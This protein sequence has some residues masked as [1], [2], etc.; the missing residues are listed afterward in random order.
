MKVKVSD[1][2]HGWILKSPMH[3]KTTRHV[4]NEQQCNKE[5]PSLGTRWFSCFICSGMTW[6]LYRAA[7][8]GTARFNKQTRW[9][10]LMCQISLL[11]FVPF[12]CFHRRCGRLSVID[13][14]QPTLVS[15]TKTHRNWCISVLSRTEVE[16]TM[17]PCDKGHNHK[18]L[19]NPQRQTV[20][21]SFRSCCR[22]LVLSNCSKVFQFAREH[23]GSENLHDLQRH[24]GS[25]K[26]Q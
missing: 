18:P 26:A 16:L 6:I 4:F 23:V 1:H 11:W 22:S 25:C 13:M 20:L 21:L 19:P 5:H 24:W 9:L 2:H 15:L 7:P 3:G 8:R 12:I 10:L 14:S 17:W